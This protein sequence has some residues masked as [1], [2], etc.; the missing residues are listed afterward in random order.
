MKECVYNYD[1]SFEGLLCCIFESYAHKESPIAIEEGQGDALTL[2]PIRTVET[3]LSHARRVL[4]KLTALSPAGTQLLQRGYLT[5]LE[6]KELH[7]YRLA[8]KLL[9]EGPRS[10]QNY[11]DE[12]VHPVAA[13]V[14]RLARE[15]EALRGFVRFSDLGG[16]LGSEIRP[17]NRVLPLLRPHFCARYPGDTFF[18]YDRTHQAILVSP[19]TKATIHPLADSQMAPPDPNEAACRLLWK[20]FFDTIAIE[21]RKDPRLQ[22]GN[23]PKRYRAVMT[24]FQPPE[25]FIPAGS[26]LAVPTPGVPVGIPAPGTL[27]GPGPFAPASAP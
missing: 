8:T 6:D 26:C 19:A 5:C 24:E 18:I 7:L 4:G 2:F 23:M 16:V 11:G 20:R 3:D 10:L 17:K 25:H 15:V 1:G 14:R 12:T 22:M 9:T 27:P 21:E 13:A